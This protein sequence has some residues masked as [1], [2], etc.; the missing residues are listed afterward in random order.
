VPSSSTAGGTKANTIASRI[1]WN[2][3]IA[4]RATDATSVPGAV[5]TLQSF[6]PTKPSPM[7]WPPPAKLKPAAVKI[8]RTLSFS[9]SRKCCSTLRSTLLVRS[10]VAPAGSVTCVNN[11]P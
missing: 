5:R 10:W 4:R 6:M 2:A 11:T 7:F 1:C 8:E 3:P 9:F